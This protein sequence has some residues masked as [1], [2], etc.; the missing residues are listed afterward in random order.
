MKVMIARMNHETN[1]FSPVPTP[2]E[3]FGN[4]GPT[5]DE[6]AY[7]DN[8]GMRTAMAAFI[9]LAEAAGAEMVTPVSAGAN[10]SGPVAARAYDE[11]CRR[12]VAAATGVDAILLDLHGAMVAENSNDGEGD[13]LERVRAAAPDTPIAVALDLHAN[14]TQKIVA[15]ADIVVGFKTYPHVDMYETGEHAGRLLFDMLAGKR[16][17][18]V[19]WQQPPLMVHSLRS[20]SHGGA[21][22]HALDAARRAEAEAGVAAVSVFSGFS[23]ADIPAPC[24]SVVVTAEDDGEAGVAR[25]QAVADRIASQA[26]DERDGFV[27]R[28]APLAESIA[29]ARRLAAGAGKPVLLLDHSDN[30]MSGGTCDTMDVLEAALAGGLTGIGVG[31]LCDPEA[32]ATLIA[33]GEGAEVTLALGNKRPLSQLGIVKTPP[34]LTG[35]VRKV[36]DGEYVV[37]GPTYTGQRCY[38][39]RTVLFDI[40]QARIVVTERTHEPWD[41]GVFTCVGLDPHNE[42]FLLLKS[43][44]Y[45][46]PVFVPISAGLVECDS[47]GVT[48]SNYA[49]FPF[50]RVK[51]PVYPLDPNATFVRS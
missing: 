45:C 22:K 29:E 2:L 1:T 50:S 18:R 27:Y 14:V 33:A 42:R 48:S 46:R 4:D 51:R 23:L 31:P 32:V 47:D 41:H 12:I 17:P 7:R 30:C 21:M 19:V 8:K 11:L 34:V 24:L 25:A 39:G 40:G 26:W 20:T 35:I 28:S 38:M 5:Y 36:S 16:R 43:R 10:P 13:L 9:D 15:N 3:A 37:T 6:A 49:L 44:M